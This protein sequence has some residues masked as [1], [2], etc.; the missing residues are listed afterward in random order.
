MENTMV[1][2]MEDVRLNATIVG[3]DIKTA[4]WA[5]EE[6][7][8]EKVDYYKTVAIWV[9]ALVDLKVYVAYRAV[10]TGIKNAMI[11]IGRGLINLAD[12]VA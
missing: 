2:T 10:R 8:A 12:S 1:S 5:V 3:C 6:V 9:V 7:V 4:Y 11:T